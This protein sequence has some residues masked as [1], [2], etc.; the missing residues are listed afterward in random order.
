MAD[1]QNEYM[2]L[3]N[4]FERKKCG[5]LDNHICP[6]R[7]NKARVGESCDG[8]S[9]FEKVITFKELSQKI[10]NEQALKQMGE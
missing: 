1:L 4:S 8:C 5:Y 6:L 10:E 9:L 7:P 3:A 2:K